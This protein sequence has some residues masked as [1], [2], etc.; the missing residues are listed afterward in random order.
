MKCP[1]K[2][3]LLPVHNG[4]HFTISADHH[5][6]KAG[7]APD[8]AFRP[9]CRSQGQQP[10][11]R[12]SQQSSVPRGIDRAHPGEWTGEAMVETARAMRSRPR[13]TP[14]TDPADID[15]G[16]MT[17]EIP[18]VGDEYIERRAVNE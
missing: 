8:D 11:E 7:I 15:H 9:V 5:V 12:V 16:A 6:A 1:A 17:A 13:S 2:R 10:I 4:S 18:A 3:W 14:L